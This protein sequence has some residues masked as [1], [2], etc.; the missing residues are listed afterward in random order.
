MN[1][2]FIFLSNSSLFIALMALSLS[3][4][5]DKLSGAP[6]NINRLLIIF[7]GT[8]I[9]YIGVQLFPNKSNKLELDTQRTLWIQTH[10]KILYIF[11]ILC[12]FVI[13]I[14]IPGLQE[15]D[16]LIFTHLFLLTIFYEKILTHK[17]ELRKIPY[18][19]PFLISY[20]WTWACT[21]PSL[22]ENSL[23]LSFWHHIECFVF[24]LALSIPF[25]IRDY[26]TDKEDHLKTIPMALG[27]TRTKCL[28]SLLFIGSL[29]IQ[30]TYLDLNLKTLIVAV[31]SFVLYLYLILKTHPMQ[32]DFY[33]LFGFDG[34]IAIKLLYLL[35]I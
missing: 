2:F 17:F 5:Y 4:Y 10:K 27:V 33:F 19:K 20:I 22:L 15:L 18:L 12:G 32:K 9:S 34:L 23:E 35:V 29:I 13:F 14:C 16:F 28:C 7:A 31:F 21:T 6:I 11:S 25:D 26:I 8:L 24:I 1:P 3:F 30:F